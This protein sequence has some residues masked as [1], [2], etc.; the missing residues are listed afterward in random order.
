MPPTRRSP[1]Q[2]DETGLFSLIGAV[3]QML[4]SKV[5]ALGVLD[6]TVERLI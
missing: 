2:A 5:Y 3:N 6:H 1:A 4:T